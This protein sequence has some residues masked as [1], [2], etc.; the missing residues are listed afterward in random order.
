MAAGLPG[1]ELAPASVI[2]RAGS[3]RSDFLVPLLDRRS[4]VELAAGISL[5][6]T[7]FVWFWAWWLSPDHVRT[8]GGFLLVTVLLVWLTIL[9]GYFLFFL[10]RARR[11][12]PDSPVPQHA[13]IAMVVTKA[14]SEPFH[15]VAATLEAMLQQTVRHD[16]WLA[17]EDPSEMT[18]AWCRARGVRVCTRS[19][20]ADY[21]RQSWPR[22][23][24]C[25]EGNLAY[26][27]DTVGYANYD[28]V[29]QLDADHVPSPTYLREILKG[30]AADDVGYVSAPSIC[31]S[32]T[33]SSWSAR[34]RLHVEGSLHGPLQA[35]YTNGWAPLCIGSHYAVR[36]RA[37]REVGGLGPELAEDHSTSLMMN[38]AGWRGVHAIDAI[39]HGDGPLTFADLVAQEFQWSRSVFTIF[40]VHLRN[41]YHQLPPRLKFQFVFSELWYP[42]FSVVML[43][44]FVLPVIAVLFD[45]PFVNVGYIDFLMHFVPM[46]AALLLLANR[47]KRWGILRPQDARA[48]S[49]EGI[50]FQL[51]RWP[52][53]LAG[54]VAAVVD[55]YRGR[56]AEFRVTP[57]GLAPGGPLPLRVFMP[58]ALL[59]VASAAPVLLVGGNV[60]AQ[61]FYIF[62]AVN[63]IS[64]GLIAAGVSLSH[65][66]A[67]GRS[68]VR[69][70]VVTTG[71]SVLLIATSLAGLS[72]RGLSGL[73]GL[74]WG[75]G[76]FRVVRT[77]FSVAGA[78]QGAVGVR[79]LNFERWTPSESLRGVH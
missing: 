9:P 45:M 66:R 13:R 19:G 67:D 10:A 55:W 69:R 56:V 16:T 50:A 30:F 12:A 33:A 39:A 11:P 78:G 51:V 43:A 62:C 75:P 31:D 4:R 74:T 37:L 32:N 42:L 65:W 48:V 1:L 15:V 57:K 23:T 58:Y 60:E 54:T 2:A 6:L 71:L 76:G 18:L 20:V 63:A 24:R 77:T 49:W 64:Y 25:K 38:A 35:G 59:S 53:T 26:F 73:E 61:G 27:Y 41:C 21:H 34:G 8:V 36:T 72:I 22:R 52:W 47:W 3:R 14:P 68:G 17:D 46:S 40:L 79:R 70:A 5:S 29:A 28:F 7:A 44:S